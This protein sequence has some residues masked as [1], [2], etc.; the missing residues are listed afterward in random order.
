ML[1]LF[2]TGELKKIDGDIVNWRLE[3][4]DGVNWRKLMEILHNIGVDW[5]D[6]RLIATL[7]MSQTAAVRLNYELTE[8][9]EVRRGVWQGCLIP[10]ILF[11][12]YAEAMMKEALDDLKEGMCAGDKLVQ[13][14]WYA[15]HQAM[16]A[17]TEKGLQKILNET[18]KVVKKYGMK[19]NI[20][21]TKVVKI[22]RQPS[23]IK[24]TVDGEILQQVEEF[25]CLGSILCS[26]GYSEKDIRV[27]IGMA[28]S[29]FNKLKK[30]LVGG[31]KLDVKKRLVKTLVSSVVM[32]ESETWTL[33]KTDATRLEAFKMWV[34]RR[35]VKVK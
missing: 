24:I 35:L 20:K 27:R 12:V 16:T 25:K 4:I 33:K 13:S 18:N 17:N 31:L 14:V 11:N 34:W 10:T 7:Y 32:Y 23:V 28:K 19:I 30:I 5:R 22:G 6:R 9:N 1:L 2:S 3:K 8:P 26:S 15:D 21:K 29:A